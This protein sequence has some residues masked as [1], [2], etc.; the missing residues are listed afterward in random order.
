LLEGVLS[1]ITLAISSG[2]SC[3]ILMDRPA[4]PRAARRLYTPSLKP[5]PCDLGSEPRR[6]CGNHA[7][8]IVQVRNIVLIYSHL[9][10]IKPIYGELKPADIAT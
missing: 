3:P 7:K 2:I 5:N 6:I 8:F 4:Y 10:Y 9:L 1:A